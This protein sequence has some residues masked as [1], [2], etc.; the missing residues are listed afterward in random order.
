MKLINYNYETTKD[1]LTFN[2][3]LAGKRKE[4]VK[5]VSK[6]DAL[7]VKVGE[8]SFSLNLYQHV[9]YPEEYDTDAAKAT[10]QHGLLTITVPKS[11]Q[12]QNEIP[13]E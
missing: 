12:K 13:V 5:V 6:P 9:W 10:M 1:T 8:Q 11:K 4:D 7:Q 2:V 3:E